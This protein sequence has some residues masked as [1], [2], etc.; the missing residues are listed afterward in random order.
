MSRSD[1]GSRE[2]HQDGLTRKQLLGSGP[3]RPPRRCLP[4][5]PASS[6][7][8]PPAKGSGATSPG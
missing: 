3:A 7:R 6:G 5:A 2:Q 4:R 8:S 1:E